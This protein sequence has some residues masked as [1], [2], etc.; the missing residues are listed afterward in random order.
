MTSITLNRMFW[1]CLALFTTIEEK[2]REVAIIAR[3]YARCSG[4]NF[5]EGSATTDS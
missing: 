5:E 3:L 4:S 1:D 2:R